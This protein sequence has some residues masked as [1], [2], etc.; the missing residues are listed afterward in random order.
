[1]LMLTTVS[2]TQSTLAVNKRLTLPDVD[3]LFASLTIGAFDFECFFNLFRATMTG[4]DDFV[5][6]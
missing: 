3:K 6:R 1:M 5:T 4:V 2:H